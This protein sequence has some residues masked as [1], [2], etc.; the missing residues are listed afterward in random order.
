M[1][2]LCSLLMLCLPFNLPQ[3]GS[4]AVRLDP[5]PSIQPATMTITSYV[6]GGQPEIDQG[7]IVQMTA[8]VPGTGCPAWLAAHHTSHGAPFL[9]VSDLQPGDTVLITDG[10]VGNVTYTVFSNKIVCCAGQYFLP[11]ADLTLQTSQ[12]NGRVYLIEASVT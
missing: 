11:T 10:R 4:P 5:P 1:R 6:R 7:L 8:C 2:L 3:A 12:A 9:H